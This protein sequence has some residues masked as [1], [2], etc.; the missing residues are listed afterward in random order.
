MSPDEEKDKEQLIEELHRLRRQVSD[1]EA[2]ETQLKRAKEE[3]VIP[4]ARWS[5]GDA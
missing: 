1:L 3:L 5:P 4:K 2:S